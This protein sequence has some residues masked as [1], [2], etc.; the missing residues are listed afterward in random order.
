MIDVTPGLYY[1]IASVWTGKLVYVGRSEG[2][3]ASRMVAGTTWGKS[4][5]RQEAIRIVK[6]KAQ[7]LRE[8]RLSAG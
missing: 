6:E 3:A 7:N 2:A 8:A 5:D 4:Q 1:A